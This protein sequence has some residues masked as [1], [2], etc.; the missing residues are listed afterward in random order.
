MLVKWISFVLVLVLMAIAE[1]P[2]D[3]R[4]DYKGLHKQIVKENILIKRKGVFHCKKITEEEFNHYY[5]KTTLDTAL[6]DSVAKKA[7]KCSLEA[8]GLEIV[9]KEKK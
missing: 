9:D 3:K 4:V 2:H 8:S 1:V 7:F 6:I 5:M